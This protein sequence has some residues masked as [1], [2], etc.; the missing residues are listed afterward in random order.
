M[1]DDKPPANRVTSA[2]MFRSRTLSG[3]LAM[4]CLSAFALGEEAATQVTAAAP[5]SA[6]EIA[7]AGKTDALSIPT[8]GELLAALNKLG[9]MDWSAKFRA[10]IAT[11]E[12]SRPK[13]AL[14]L[15]EI[16]RASCRE[17]V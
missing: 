15:G 10:P 3:G 7:G 8:P 13:M 11:S 17:R 16:G 4:L 14:N 9:K 2:H 12:A 5:L 1:P 6:E